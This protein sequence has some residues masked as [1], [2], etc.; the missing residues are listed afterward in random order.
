[1]TQFEKLALAEIQK[2][3]D[4]ANA[5]DAFDELLNAQLGARLLGLEEQKLDM[6]ALSTM[7]DAT[8]DEIARRT[9]E[10]DPLTRITE[11]QLQALGARLLG[12]PEHKPNTTRLSAERG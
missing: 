9:I 6:T 12:L 7:D 11:E 1:M 3:H 2:I 10:S 4:M 5:M 8:A